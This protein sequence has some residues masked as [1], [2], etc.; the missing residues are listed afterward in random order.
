MT[1]NTSV[2]LWIKNW[3]V[4]YIECYSMSTY[5]GVQ[6]TVRFFGPPCMC[7]IRTLWCSVLSARV[8]KCQKLK[9]WVRPVWPWVLWS[10]T[11]DVTGLQKVN[12]LI[13]LVH[14]WTFWAWRS[15]WF[16]SLTFEK[17][18]HCITQKWL[19]W[20]C[21]STPNSYLWFLLRF[22]HFIQTLCCRE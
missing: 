19:N 7:D 4:W 18:H 9:L 14:W 2:L 10:V 6:K 1:H 13:R 20:R 5:T 17:H 12:T 3:T 22:L 8:A 16:N 11:F 21:W 15:C